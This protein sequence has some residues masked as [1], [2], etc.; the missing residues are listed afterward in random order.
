MKERMRAF[1][2]LLCVILSVE[3]ALCQK[4]TKADHQANLVPAGTATAAKE[5]MPKPHWTVKYLAGSLHLETDSWL[6]I[7]FAPQGT[8][9]GRNNLFITVLADQIVSVE[10]SAKAE[11]DSDRIQGPRSGCGYA[12]TMMPDLAK[13]RPDALIAAK[14]TPGRASRFADVL[15]RHHPVHIV[16]TEDGKQERMTVRINDCEYESFI[17]NLRWLLGAR[18]GE[19]ARDISK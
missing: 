14:S 5:L 7:A 2:T 17:A 12:R 8:A 18:W 15:I 16:W 13:S 1:L 4:A 10:Y 11:R 6:T 9:Q 3:I 19:A